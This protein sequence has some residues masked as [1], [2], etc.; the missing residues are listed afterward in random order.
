MMDEQGG[1]DA[2]FVDPLPDDLTCIVCHLALKDPVQIANCGHRFCNICFKKI[3]SYS[4]KRNEEFTCPVDRKKIAENLVFSDQAASRAVLSLK[5]KCEQY[6]K[7][8]TWTGDLGNLQ[9]HIQKTCTKRDTPN[10]ELISKLDSQ[11]KDMMARMVECE[12]CTI[13][14]KQQ[15]LSLQDKVQQKE[16][17]I[18]LL[19]KNME[20]N[21]Q[22]KDKEIEEL[23]ARV[24]TLEE[25]ESIHDIHPMFE[26]KIEI[27]EEKL[28]QTEA[29]VVKIEKL[30]PKM[31]AF[32][33]VLDNYSHQSENSDCAKSPFF[34]NYLNG[35][36]CQLSLQWFNRRKSRIGIYFNL[37]NKENKHINTTFDMKVVIQCIGENNIHKSSILKDMTYGK[38]GIGEEDSDVEESSSEFCHR[39]GFSNDPKVSSSEISESFGDDY[40]LCQPELNNFIVNDTMHFVCYLI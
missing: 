5:V 30:N 6:E 28:C 2:E 39:D 13:L 3:Q 18:N 40:F 17:K 25:N 19:E 38:E 21:L 37:P 29:R 11:M 12:R 16:A 27:C 22:Q 7:G 20:R 31:G 15:I 4:H 33:W 26:S 8:C 9:D 23:T 1:Y 32:K 24:N 14:Q 10:K 35:H 36:V 34:H